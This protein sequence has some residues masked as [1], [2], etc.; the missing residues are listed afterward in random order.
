MRK[1]NQ[2]KT[3]P[4][5]IIIVG[6]GHHFGRNII[7]AAIRLR[8]EGLIKILTT[9]DILNRGEKGHFDNVAHIKRN[10]K[11]LHEQLK[12]FKKE[13]P[14]VILGHT[15]SLHAKDAFD[16]LSH[17]FR[18]AIEKPYALDSKSLH[19]FL[20]IAKKNRCALLEYYL[21]MKSTAL[22]WGY[23]EID[24]K[25]FYVTDWL[26]KSS[27]VLTKYAP[28]LEGFRN[29]LPEVIGAIQRVEVE[30]LEGEG[31]TGTL[32][33]RGIDTIDTKSGGGMIQDM[34]THALVPLLA[35]EKIIGSF[36][37]KRNFLVRTARCKEYMSMAKRRFAI[38][39]GRIGETYAEVMFTTTK[40]IPVT[41]RLGKYVFGD[42]NRRGVLLC[43]SKGEAYLDMNDCTLYVNGEAVIGVDKSYYHTIR[44]A[45]AEI[46]RE[47]L[48][49]FDS[50]K[51]AAKAQDLVFDIQRLA[52]KNKENI[53]YKTGADPADIFMPN[54]IRVKEKINE[55]AIRPEDS[56]N[57]WLNILGK[58]LSDFFPAHKRIQTACPGC[59]SAE[60]ESEFIKLGF[61]YKWCKN[62][63]SLYASPRPT[64]KEID[65]FYKSSKAMKFYGEN[66]FK[67]T[68]EARYEH[69]ITPLSSWVKSIML[70]YIPAP[71]KI[72]DFMPKFYSVWAEALPPSKKT[73]VS[74]VNPVHLFK[75]PSSFKVADLSEAKKHKYDLITAFD[76][77]DHRADPE[78]TIKDL[79][80]MCAKGGILFLTLNSGSG[81]E[82]QVLSHDSHRLVPPTRLNLLTI[83]A[84]EDMLLKNNFELL[85]VS[86]SGKLD[87]DIVLKAILGDH[88]VPVP[89]FISYLLKKK[90]TATWESL[91]AFLQLNNL[92]S[93]LRIAARKK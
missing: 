57:E 31:E 79:S 92:S 9:I 71:L 55:E 67:A 45:V 70:K 54:A 74:L 47:P 73:K 22:L 66:I 26:I 50:V 48:F 88:S 8:E 69:Q 49:H 30:V 38:P 93:F 62:C 21:A 56:H 80:E 72:L 44:A 23:G 4:V 89:R 51:V 29:K 6:T 18:V 78:K 35:L 15:N 64:E 24:R 63:F 76:V 39:V 10:N 90:G 1:N 87:V 40:K 58:E 12:E 75:T 46:S 17:G 59:S 42:R 61:I 20:K 32:E 77:L 13:D 25:S 34:G 19:K 11:P 37:D 27:P 86:T 82:Y 52:Y 14:L 36:P 33:G 7:P 65:A 5:P 68:I 53:C 91:Q 84:M 60:V 83:E 2:V 81:F 43:G 28:S 41:I 16:L 85:D 3:R